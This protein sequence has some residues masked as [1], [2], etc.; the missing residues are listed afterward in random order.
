MPHPR[1]LLVLAM[2]ALGTRPCCGAQEME[3]VDEA[4]YFEEEE[5]FLEDF[6]IND[7]ANGLS[8]MG[9]L[10]G[11]SMII[12]VK[13]PQGEKIGVFK[14]TSGN[15]SHISEI[16]SYQLCRR[17]K[18]PVCAPAVL[19]TLERDTLDKF[20]A[21]L[22]KRR[23]E[24]PE[25]SRHA[26]HY[27]MKERYRKAMVDK[28]RQAD[29]LEGVLKTWISPL[30]LYESLGTVETVKKH[31][32]YPFLRH[33]GP[34]PGEEVLELRQCTRI[35]KPAGCYHAR[36]YLD[37]LLE[38]FTGM[39]IVDAV[40]GNTDRFAGGNVHLFSLEARYIKEK[41][42]SYRLPSASLLMLDNGAGLMRYPRGGL[43]LIKKHLEITRFF[44]KHYD[45]LLMLERDLRDDRAGVRRELGLVERY[46]HGG[47][48]FYPAKIFRK[49]LRRLIRYLDSLEKAHSDNA[50]L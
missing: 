26:G 39:L 28:L 36:V 32:L 21:L 2:L 18:L 9:D 11:S 8:L 14:P 31:P 20:A 4:A 46:E 16:V 19:K 50:W 44:P 35:Y 13:D 12:K 5:R 25:G 23:F 34:L 1:L 7:P 45:A 33:D 30:V 15:T 27:E 29:S 6:D 22:E 24:S 41:K 37:E 49:N 10:E 42:R 3:M 17:L 43:D 38:Q 48:T 47:R 40:I